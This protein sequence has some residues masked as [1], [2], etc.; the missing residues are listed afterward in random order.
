[1]FVKT[2]LD[3]VDKGFLRSESECDILS[4]NNKLAFGFRIKDFEKI[5]EKNSSELSLP[6]DIC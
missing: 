2:F 4:V 5:I 1:V 6:T 3:L